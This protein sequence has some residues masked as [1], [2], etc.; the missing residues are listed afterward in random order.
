MHHGTGSQTVCHTEPQQTHGVSHGV[1]WSFT[2]CPLRFTLSS[3]PGSTILACL[4]SHAILVFVILT[5]SHEILHYFVAL[6]DKAPYRK[7]AMT[8]VGLGIAALHP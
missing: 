4:R 3:V 6:A 2:R 5:I 8:K 1:S 7:G